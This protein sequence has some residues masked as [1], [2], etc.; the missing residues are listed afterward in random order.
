MFFL[1]VSEAKFGFWHCC[2][3]LGCILT[4]IF[5]VLGLFGLHSLDKSAHLRFGDHAWVYVLLVILENM[6]HN[7]FQAIPL[8]KIWLQGDFIDSFN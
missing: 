4:G 5:F 2:T 3:E 1:L 7:V 6:T 8:I